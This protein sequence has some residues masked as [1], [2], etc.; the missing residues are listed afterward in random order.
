MTTPLTPADSIG[1]ALAS[2]NA[3]LA[4]AGSVLTSNG[5]AL[6][7]ASQP[8]HLGIWVEGQATANEIVWRFH[9]PINFVLTGAVG[10]SD[11]A[12]VAAIAYSLTVNNTVVGVMN[13]A[14]NA[15]V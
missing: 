7:Y 11:V 9:A 5:S 1:A 10:S 8:Y 15:I 12:P 2:H 4:P 13:F 3:S 14:A 6:V